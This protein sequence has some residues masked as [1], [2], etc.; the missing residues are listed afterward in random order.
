MWGAL[1][2]IPVIT[3]FHSPKNN[4]IW[5]ISLKLTLVCVPTCLKVYIIQVMMLIQNWRAEI[6]QEWIWLS[7]C[8]KDCAALDLI[9]FGRS[10]ALKP[11]CILHTHTS[12]GG[13]FSSKLHVHQS[14]N[15]A[16]YASP[17]N[18][19]SNTKQLP[20]HLFT[21]TRVSVVC[22]CLV[23]H[24]TSKWNM[25]VAVSASGVASSSSVVPMF[26]SNSK[27]GSAR[28]FPCVL[29]L[30]L[31]RAN[32]REAFKSIY[33]RHFNYHNRGIDSFEWCMAF[34]CAHCTAV[35]ISLTHN[36]AFTGVSLALRRMHDED[37]AE[38][39]K[40][41]R[42]ISRWMLEQRW[43]QQLCWWISSSCCPCSVRRAS[44]HGWKRQR[45]MLAAERSYNTKIFI[46]AKMH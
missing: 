26:L 37:F 31:C 12:I 30:S 28:F 8:K 9:W 11:E 19:T 29:W 45:R 17:A 3:I 27:K 4:K 2:R 41:N 39:E 18:R 36:H 24:E 22:L 20:F 7:D 5:P 33:I 44:F 13:Y 10:F 40:I 25:H 23:S 42:I 35:H 16:I 32:G 15:G 14:M 38:R 46:F 34:V 21:R 1:G 43:R 6:H